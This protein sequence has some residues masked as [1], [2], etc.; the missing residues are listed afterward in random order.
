VHI[1]SLQQAFVELGHELVEFSLVARATN[2]TPAKPAAP[3]AR[4]SWSLLSHLP[5]FARELAEYSYTAFARPRLF[6][7]LE[8]EQ[9]D[10][11]YER[12]AF[13]NAAGVMAARRAKL[14]IVLEVNSPMVR[15]LQSLGADR[16]GRSD[17]LETSSALESIDSE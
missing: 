7:M 2:L 8:R 10:F 5:R 9:P 11:V 14:P 12:Y 13:G 6:A 4:S 1:R 15:G 17:G 16:R 3:R